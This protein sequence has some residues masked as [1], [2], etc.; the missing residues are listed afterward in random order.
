MWKPVSILF[1]CVMG[2][3]ASAARIA[4][5]GPAKG[6]IAINQDSAVEHQV[7]D[8]VCLVKDG[9]V[10]GCGV[11]IRTAGKA[12]L[13]SLNSTA[14]APREGDDV[15]IQKT[16]ETTSAKTASPE[17]IENKATTYQF[18]Q[19]NFSLGAFSTSFVVQFSQAIAEKWALGLMASFGSAAAGAGTISGYNFGATLQ[20]FSEDPYNGIWVLLGVGTA[21]LT[22]QVGAQSE[23]AGSAFVL[24]GAGYRYLFGGGW[25]IGAGVGGQYYFNSELGHNMNGSGVSLDFPGFLPLFLLDVGYRF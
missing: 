10:L 5:V 25:N 2:V 1:V 12:V 4:K 15:E 23:K 22:P 14:Q 3:T 17:F 11:V 13:I 16:K 18:D 9:K 7:N 24:G 21:F 19:K 6:M 20:F 8:P